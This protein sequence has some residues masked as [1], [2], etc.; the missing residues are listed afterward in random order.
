MSVCFLCFKGVANDKGVTRQATIRKSKGTAFRLGI[1]P[2]AFAEHALCFGTVETVRFGLAF[3]ISAGKDCPE[4][5]E[6]R[7]S[8][9]V[10]QDSDRSPVLSLDLR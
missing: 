7:H 5:E 3:T 6:P 8:H 4:I 10:I 9:N 1:V 2:M